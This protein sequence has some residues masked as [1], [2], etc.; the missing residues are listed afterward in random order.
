MES[1]VK[2][3]IA[4]LEKSIRKVKSQG[5]AFHSR[6]VYLTMKRLIGELE[7]NNLKIGKKSAQCSNI[8]KANKA[9]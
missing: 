8:I 7:A 6:T 3:S 5:Y 9:L 1:E 2:H 4:T